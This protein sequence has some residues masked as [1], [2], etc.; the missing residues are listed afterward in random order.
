MYGLNAEIFDRYTQSGV[1]IANFNSELATV[2]SWPP[3]STS[4]TSERLAGL[5]VFP[6][7]LYLSDVDQ[8]LTLLTEFLN[9]GG[10]GTIP[11]PNGNLRLRPVNGL[12]DNSVELFAM[13]LQSFE[14][15]LFLHPDLQHMQAPLRAKGLHFNVDW[16][17]F[18]LCATTVDQDLTARYLPEP[19]I[20]ARAEVVYRFYSSNLPGI[21]MTNAIR[22]RQLNGLRFIPRRQ[23]RSPSSS[24]PTDP[25]C[26]PLPGIVSPSQILRGKYEQIAWTQR[27]LCEEE[28]TGLLGTLNPS[29]GVP[30][31][32][33]V[34]SVRSSPLNLLLI[35][36][37]TS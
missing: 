22:W 6:D 12:Y 18:L 33:E 8:Y 24:F 34:V 9:I 20:L 37:T 17:S 15:S 1:A 31:A 2:L 21:V 4:V 29:F 25:Y 5:L 14:Q 26:E 35:S 13:A 23:N 3:K 7:S 28:P 30:T 10:A 11:V 16:E 36:H 32:A 19:D 27:A